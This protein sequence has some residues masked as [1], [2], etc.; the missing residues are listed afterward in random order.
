[1]N[2]NSLLLQSINRLITWP[3]PHSGGGNVLVDATAPAMNALAQLCSGSGS[4]GLTPAPAPATPLSPNLIPA[5]AA[6]AAWNPEM[7][8]ILDFYY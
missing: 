6:A 2:A 1:M 3:H 7:E 4:L 8:G 5:A